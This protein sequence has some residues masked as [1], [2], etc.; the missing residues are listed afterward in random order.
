MMVTNVRRVAD[1][2]GAPLN[3]RQ[4]QPPVVIN[5][6]TSLR[7]TAMPRMVQV[8]AQHQ[9]RQVVTFHPRAV[10]CPETRHLPTARTE[11][12]ASAR[13]QRT[14]HCT[15]LLKPCQRGATIAG[16]V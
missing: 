13:V 3:A 1:K 8:G 6:I 5:V 2:R 15:L 10:P 11:R 16:G 4:P 7:A 9:R 12:G 14:M